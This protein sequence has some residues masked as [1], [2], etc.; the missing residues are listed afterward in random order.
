MSTKAEEF[1][2]W[3][4]RSGAKKAKPAAR[5]RKAAGAKPAAPGVGG[6][7]LGVP[8]KTSLR[9]G[10]KALYA[11]EVVAPG[12]RPSRKSTRKATNRQRTDTQMQVK[13]RT[14]EVR[15]SS[16]AGLRST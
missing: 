11:L 13:L 16:R 4:E 6:R 12:T 7:E 5:P 15:P 1:R 9:A 14:Q 2:Y 8:R 3:R 10:K